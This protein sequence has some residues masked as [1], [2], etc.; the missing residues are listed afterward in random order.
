MKETKTQK[1]YS[2]LVFVCF[3][4][5]TVLSFTPFCGHKPR[6]LFLCFKLK[7]WSIIAP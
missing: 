2:C 6:K 1:L 7:L 3:V 4:K 5:K